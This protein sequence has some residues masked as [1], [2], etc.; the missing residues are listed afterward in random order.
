MAVDTVHTCFTKY[1]FIFYIFYVLEILLYTFSYAKNNIKNVLILDIDNQ[2]IMYVF[3]SK[4]HPCSMFALKSSKTSK[5]YC[6][7][8]IS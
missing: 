3:T 7:Q 1:R 2:N 4:G 5:F 6:T 8:R